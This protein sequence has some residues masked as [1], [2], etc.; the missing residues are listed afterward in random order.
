M[1]NVILFVC[2]IIFSYSALF[3]QSKEEK[4]LYKEALRSYE[5][6]DYTIAID[7]YKHLMKLN[8][9]NF[10]YPYDIALIYFHEL[11]Q[12]YNSIS[13]FELA[14][15]LMKNDSIPELYF[16]LAQS[17]QS[18][19][20]FDKS[21]EAFNHYRDIDSSFIKVNTKRYVE[22]CNYG[23]EM[24]KNSNKNIIIE[25]IGNSVNSSQADY[26]FIELPNSKDFLF[27][28][29]RYKNIYDE[30]P[31]AIFIGVLND[32]KFEVINRADSSDTYKNLVFDANEFQSIVN[33]SAD[34][35]TLILY[36]DAFLYTSELKAGI[37]QIPVKLPDQINF[38]FSNRHASLTADGSTIY[39]STSDRKNQNNIDIYT[40][41]KLDDGTWSIAKNLGNI[42]NTKG[43]EDSPEISGDG[44]T[45]HFSSNGHKGLGGFDIFV[46][47]KQDTVWSTPQN[48]GFPI[49]SVRNDIYYK[50]YNATKAYISS[51]RKDGNGDMDIYLIIGE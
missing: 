34:G 37:W 32:Q 27:T 10:N 49:N 40:S 6:G 18:D 21:I 24:I 16:L 1:R 20:E 25:N 39:F 48:M 4:K 46:S 43:A 12:R 23:L 26:I 17:Y 33:I 28:S 11:N 7:R 8:S 47:H 51:N 50:K 30:Y 19:G 3:A 45:L 38:N 2:L 41:T 36:Y 35:K 29:R 15:K 42:I 5:N 9:K 44:K 31:E 14:E 13:Y 22:N